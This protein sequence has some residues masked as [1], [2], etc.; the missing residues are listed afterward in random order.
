M[1]DQRI[2]DLR[3]LIALSERLGLAP[4]AA[5]HAYVVIDELAADVGALRRRLGVQEKEAL[6]RIQAE[7]PEPAKIEYPGQADPGPPA[8]RSTE[9]K[10]CHIL[11][12]IGSAADREAVEKILKDPGV[13]YAKIVREFAAKGIA[14][15]DMS[16]RRHRVRGAH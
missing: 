2:D 12:G 6:E 7:L 3:D 14:I 10:V 5:R 15:S 9:C 8:R 1:K 13:P 16:V 11:S 4:F